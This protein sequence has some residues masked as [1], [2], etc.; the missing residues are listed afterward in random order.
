[1][2]VYMY[3][4]LTM[5]SYSWLYH[6][7]DCV[8]VFSSYKKLCFFLSNQLSAICYH[9]LDKAA[10]NDRCRRALSGEERREDNKKYKQH[11]L[12]RTR[13]MVYRF[14]CSF[15]DRQ[16]ICCW[17]QRIE[18]ETTVL[19]RC[20]CFLCFFLSRLNAHDAS[21]ICTIYK[22]FH[23]CSLSPGVGA[24]GLLRV[25]RYVCFCMFFSSHIYAFV[26]CWLAFVLRI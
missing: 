11:D 1:M 8:W 4:P 20:F 25:E 17:V 15:I 19:I 16:V 18:I 21:A 2:Y 24:E 22:I 23:H 12:L 9:V 10:N 3:I 26:K 14:K 13:K 7:K 6:F 5:F